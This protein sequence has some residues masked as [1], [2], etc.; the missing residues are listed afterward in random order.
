MV[1]RDTKHFTDLTGAL[2][3]VEACT[4]VMEATIVE[5]EKRF[6]HTLPVLRMQSAATLSPLHLAF[7]LLAYIPLHEG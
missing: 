5:Y 2:Q 1:R 4:A 7:P 6:T 3:K